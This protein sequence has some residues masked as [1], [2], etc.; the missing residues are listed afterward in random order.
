M[1]QRRKREHDSSKK[2]EPVVFGKRSS[3]KNSR[4]RRP[5]MKLPP[6][7]CCETWEDFDNKHNDG[8][9]TENGYQEYLNSFRK[10]FPDE[11]LVSINVDNIID[12]GVLRT[13]KIL[14]KT[15]IV[16]HYS[17]DGKDVVRLMIKLKKISR[18]K[19]ED[20]SFRSHG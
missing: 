6:C 15:D 2:N 19:E 12:E 16:D 8:E 18:V 7:N 3:K 11:V 14:K 17:I 5:K 10:D 1:Q 4:S 13:L 20:I 9:W